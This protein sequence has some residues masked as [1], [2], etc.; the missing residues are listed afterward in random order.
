MAP[1]LHAQSYSGP[2]GQ[3][4][5][6][7]VDQVFRPDEA[8]R[9]RGRVAVGVGLAVCVAVAV[10][11]GFKVGAP[12]PAM[13]AGRRTAWFSTGE[14]PLVGVAVG[15]RVAVAVAA[16]PVAVSKAW[17]WACEWV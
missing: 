2:I 1:P 3:P 10:G 14:G 15:V 17:P 11:V 7:H 9:R 6:A 4:K 16:G 13:T 5:C 12:V 8:S